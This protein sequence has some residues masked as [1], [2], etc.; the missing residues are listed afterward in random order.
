L[1]SDLPSAGADWTEGAAM[2]PWTLENHTD[3][4]TLPD[5]SLHAGLAAIGSKN[6]FYEKRPCGPKS[7]DEVH[8]SG[9]VQTL[10]HRAFTGFAVTGP[11][12]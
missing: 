6:S 5:R 3:V 1:D 8:L 9:K 2:G 11:D 4:R 7:F 12:R 10:R